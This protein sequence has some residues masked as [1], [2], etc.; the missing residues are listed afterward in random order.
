MTVNL[1]M[2]WLFIRQK[3]ENTPQIAK[4]QQ[5]REY[6]TSKCQV[7]GAQFLHLACQ[8]GCS[9]SC[10]LSVT[11]LPANELTMQKLNQLIE[12]KMLTSSF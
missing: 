12:I 9:S 6:Y 10:P 1:W 2:S 4:K 7:K 11:P 3:N 5:I 8:G